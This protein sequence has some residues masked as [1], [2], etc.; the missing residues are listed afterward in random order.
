MRGS[1]GRAHVEDAPRFVFS[2]APFSSCHCVV[3]TQT[4]LR[5]LQRSTWEF[6][7]AASLAQPFRAAM[8]FSRSGCSSHSHRDGA[9]LVVMG[10][11]TSFAGAAL[12]IVLLSS[13]SFQ[14]LPSA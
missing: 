5:P 10:R 3:W 6:S 9:L 13:F 12:S 8:A 2:L 4:H 1:I 11:G 14:I 7:S